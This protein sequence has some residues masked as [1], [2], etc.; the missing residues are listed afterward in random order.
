MVL[1]K[2][3]EEL[4]GRPTAELSVPGPSAVYAG[5]LALV[6]LVAGLFWGPLDHSADLGVQP[7]RDVPTAEMRV[8]KGGPR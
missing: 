2:P 8:A 7:F 1:E 5:L 6:L 4:E 3:L